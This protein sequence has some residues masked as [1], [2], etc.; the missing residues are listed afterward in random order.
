MKIIDKSIEG[1]LIRVTEEEL[2]LLERALNT[3]LD[4][5]EYKDPDLLLQC[6]FLLTTLGEGVYYG[7]ASEDRPRRRYRGDYSQGH[8]SKT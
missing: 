6:K 1:T 8:G 7:K 5:A 4:D 2:Y 3:M